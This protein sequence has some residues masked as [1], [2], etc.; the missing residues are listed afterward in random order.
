MDEKTEALRE[1]FVQVTEE[2]TV[3][4]TQTESRGSL[5]DERSAPEALGDVVDR[6][7]EEFDFATSLPDSDLVHIVEDFY[8]G[9]S[10]TEMANDLDV[11]RRTIVRARLDLHLIRERDRESPFDFET[12]ETL[13][14]DGFSN[15]EIGF[16]LDVSASTVRRYRRIIEAQTEMRRV[17]E[18]FRSEFEDVLVDADLGDT[19]TQD[20]TADG[21][22][23]ATEG[24]ETNVSF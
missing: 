1:L 12:L 8:R 23:D 18:R 24:M 11:S 22:E 14:R 13:H 5:T 2:D 17:S 7:R 9:A 4:E 6:M 16:R 21:L 3:T 19:L 20:V 15:E 10:D